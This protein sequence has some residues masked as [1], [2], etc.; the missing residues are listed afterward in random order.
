MIGP[1]LAY[2]ALVI[3]LPAL[4]LFLLT[5]ALECLEKWCQRG[6]GT[7]GSTMEDPWR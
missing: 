5:T 2:L 1:I 6:D 3:G 7:V 4:M